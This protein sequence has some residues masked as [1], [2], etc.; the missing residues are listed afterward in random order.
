MAQLPSTVLELSSDD[1]KDDLALSDI[2]DASS[3]LYAS[4]VK[5]K[6][7]LRRGGK[8]Q[9][10][11]SDSDANDDVKSEVDML[12]SDTD[13]RGAEFQHA[14]ELAKKLKGQASNK[15][16]GKGRAVDSN[17]V[18]KSVSR[19]LKGK[20]KAT[21]V[22]SSASS[23]VK[24]KGKAKVKR[25]R[26]VSSDDSGSDFKDDGAS[27]SDDMSVSTINDDDDMLLDDDDGEEHDFSDDDE[28]S[29]SPAS[30][31]KNNKAKKDKDLGPKVPTRKGYVMSK[32]EKKE[33]SKLPAV[34]CERSASTNSLS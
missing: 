13:D 30:K 32:K 15:S 16:K 24:G 12:D 34:S 29:V 2:N 11:D 22:S 5:G 7:T 27:E 25:I 9:V 31:A 8:K 6:P 1:D 21:T 19:A 17:E 33:L 14:R 28:S 10:P 4:K 20:G 26:D 23:V 3:H 18:A